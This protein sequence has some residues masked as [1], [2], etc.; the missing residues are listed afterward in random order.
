MSTRE[1]RAKKYY[2]DRI[3][4]DGII[5]ILINFAYEEVEL[6]LKRGEK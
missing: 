6:A 5:E 1:E 3:E 4:T 2:E